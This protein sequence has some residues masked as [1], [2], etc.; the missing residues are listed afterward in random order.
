MLNRIPV[1]LQGKDPQPA[2]LKNLPGL[3]ERTDK[4]ELN[5]HQTNDGMAAI[6]QNRG[7][8]DGVIIR[9]G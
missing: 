8:Q 1:S 7:E 3:M 5:N 6:L 4:P 2:P 9:I